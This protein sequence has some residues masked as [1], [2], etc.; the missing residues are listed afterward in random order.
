MSTANKLV[1]FFVVILS[2]CQCDCNVNVGV[3]TVFNDV[4]VPANT[5]LTFFSRC[6][7]PEITGFLFQEPH[8]N[9]HLQQVKILPNPTDPSDELPGSSARAPNP[10]IEVVV[11][12]TEPLQDRRVQVFCQSLVL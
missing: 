8:E 2:G 6:V 12:N 3:T 1:P 4:L 9:I 10:G 5:T 11:Q 7:T